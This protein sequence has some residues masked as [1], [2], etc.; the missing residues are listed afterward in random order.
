MLGTLADRPDLVLVMTDQQRYD[1]LGYQT[2]GGLR[3]ASAGCRGVLGRG[4][5]AG[6]QR[7]DNVR[8]R[9]R[10]AAHGAAPPPTPYAENGQALA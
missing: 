9:S 8:P 3:D 5:R 10:V 7:V 4:L 2:S 6:V 1:Q